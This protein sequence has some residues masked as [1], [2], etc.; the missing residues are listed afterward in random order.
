MQCSFDIYNNGDHTLRETRREAADDPSSFTYTLNSAEGFSV[1]YCRD[2]SKKAGQCIIENQQ[3]FIQMSYTVSG[4]KQ[5]QLHSG[6]PPLIT[7]SNNEY[8]YLLLNKQQI[9]LHWQDNET[10]EFFELGISPVLFLQHLPPEHPFY[11]TVR[12]SMDRNISSVINT[13]NLPLSQTLYTMLFQVLHCPLEGPY[14]QLYIKSK[15]LEL[16]AFQLAQYEQLYGPLKSEAPGN[17]LKKDDV[18]RMHHA[19]S[20]ILSNI[21]SPCSLIDLAHQVGTNEAYLK[22]HFK[23]VFNNTVFGYL[24]NV[25]MDLARDLLLQGNTV[26]EVADRSG[27]KHAAHFARA[28]KKHFGIPPNKIKK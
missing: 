28:F 1:C 4:R 9:E 2:Q 23:L 19:R 8:N 7:L 12:N 17:N 6:T 10:I 22:K 18:E 24:H 25:K 20:I 15:L 11:T 26:A 5:Y 16:L 14:K 27:Y 3:P 13:L 21:D